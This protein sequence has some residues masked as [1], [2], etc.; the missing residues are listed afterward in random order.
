MQN[1]LYLII[2]VSLFTSVS[3]LLFRHK[4]KH[5]L[6]RI[7]SNRKAESYFVTI[8]HRLLTP[9]DSEEIAK[10]SGYGYITFRI[11]ATE[12]RVIVVMT[13]SISVHQDNKC[14]LVAD[15]CGNVITNRETGYIFSY[16][17]FEHYLSGL[18]GDSLVYA[19]Q[20]S[21]IVKS[22]NPKSI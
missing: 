15:F 22:K 21:T 17:S 10:E 13:R 9:F 2:L 6:L 4:R 8:C 11:C 5:Q 18:V 7:E 1:I 14:I 16:G 19:S 20:I 3:I 12:L